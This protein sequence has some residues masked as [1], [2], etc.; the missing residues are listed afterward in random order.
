MHV[1][2]SYVYSDLLLVFVDIYLHIS[3]PN[4][5]NLVS[6]SIYS[7]QIFSRCLSYLHHNVHALFLS[8]IKQKCVAALCT[9]CKS[10]LYAIAISFR[11]ICVVDCSP[12]STCL[13]FTSLQ[14]HLLY[15]RLFTKQ[16]IRT[17]KL[18]IAINIR[19]MVACS[20][21]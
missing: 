2:K 19:A 17:T 15:H 12:M 21:S 5:C 3:T 9:T 14:Y 20:V 6:Q 8:Y 16:Y 13:C 1:Q 7:H 18:L 11:T 4:S 10:Y